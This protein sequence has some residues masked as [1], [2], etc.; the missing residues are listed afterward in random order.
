MKLGI[1][2]T[3]KVART[4]GTAWSTAGHDITY[5]SRE[6][7]DQKLDHPVLGLAETVEQA[8]VVVNAILGAFALDTIR[9]LDP[10]LFAGKT[11]IDVANAL[12]PTFSLSYPDT[13]LGQ[14]L[15]AALPDAH[16]VKTLNTAAIGVTTAPG[17]LA[18]TTLFLSGD[19][20]EAKAQAAGLLR[21]LGWAEGSAVDLGGI[22]SAHAAEHYFLMFV[23][24]AQASGSEQFNVRVV[25]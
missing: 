23:A 10:T 12:T 18:D 19:D 17:R 14:E 3:G 21:D 2:G 4:L 8:D 16:V 13:S 11:F 15:Q 24:I 9:T 6:P 7:V 20:D 1:L 5:G 25:R 22:D